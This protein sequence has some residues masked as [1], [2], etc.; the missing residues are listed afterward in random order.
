MIDEIL[1]IT[2]YQGVCNEDLFFTMDI[3][4]GDEASSD[5]RG[6]IGWIVVRYI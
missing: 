5:H 4:P 2:T 3:D 6:L 1:R